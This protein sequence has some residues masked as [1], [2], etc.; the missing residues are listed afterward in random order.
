MFLNIY[1]LNSPIKRIRVIHGKS[2]SILLLYPRNVS[3]APIVSKM[4]KD[5]P[6]KWT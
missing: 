5:I 1:G 3:L 6:S 4:G 2:G